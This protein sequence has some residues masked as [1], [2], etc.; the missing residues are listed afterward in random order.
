MPTVATGATSIPRVNEPYRNTRPG[1]LVTNKHAELVESPGMPLVA[2][3]VTNSYPL[4]DASQVFESQCLARLSSFLYQGLTNHMVRVFLKTFLASAHFLQ[5]TF[6]RTST[7]LLQD[8]TPL[9]IAFTHDLDL[10]TAKRFTLTIGCRGDYP[11]INAEHSTG[12]RLFWCILTLRDMQVI[13]TTSPDQIS[14]ADF[15][16]AIYQ[17]SMLTVAQDKTAGGAPLQGIEGDT[18]KTHKAIGTS[19]IADRTPWPELWA[20]LTF[21]DSCG[22]DSLNSLS[23]STDRKLSTKPEAR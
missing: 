3:F 17:H 23:T 14:T 16:G 1:S 15:P 20:C 12:Y 10:S 18:I 13:G 8:L 5:A 22:L 2:V 11:Q 19:I 6:R 7:Y 9:V 21:L 4:P